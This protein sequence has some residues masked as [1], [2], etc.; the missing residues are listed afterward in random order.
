MFSLGF[1]HGCVNYCAS[2]CNHRDMC[3]KYVYIYIHIYVYVY[4]VLH[5]NINIYT[6]NAYTILKYIY[7][8]INIQ[9]FSVYVYIN[10]FIHGYICIYAYVYIC[11]HL[12]T[13]NVRVYV[14][15]HVRLTWVQL[16]WNVPSL[17]LPF[18]LV[19]AQPIPG[20]LFVVNLV[21]G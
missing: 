13:P 7:I 1:S 21:L 16:D 10:I 5:I 2:I 14:C 20:Y 4:S 11:I 17:I 3:D 8:Y 15:R 19:C 12:Y 18:A 9:D 6:Y